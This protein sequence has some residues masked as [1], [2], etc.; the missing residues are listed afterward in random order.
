V[1]REQLL[2]LSSIG[3]DLRP[4]RQVRE[5][6]FV[7]VRHL[8]EETDPAEWDSIQ[9]R[10]WPSTDPFPPDEGPYEWQVI[11]GYHRTSAARLL[12]MSTLRASIVEAETETAFTLLAIKGNLRHGKPMSSD[13]QRVVVRRLRTLGLSEGEIARQTGIPKG[14]VH[15]WLSGR[16]TNGGRSVRMHQLEHNT[17]YT[18]D[19]GWQVKPAHLTSREH[20]NLSG[21]IADFLASTPCDITPAH[22]VALIQRM[23]LYERQ[24]IASDVEKTIEWL[25]RYQAALSQSIEEQVAS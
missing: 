1:D 24:S 9:V 3:L 18:L 2:S 15:N 17:E 25:R 21:T 11:S 7:W 6:D 8:A 12:N 13:E 20:I 16:N 10:R 4:E 19:A 23:T 22:A 14:T 5:L